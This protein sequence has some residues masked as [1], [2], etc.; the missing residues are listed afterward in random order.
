MPNRLKPNFKIEYESA[1]IVCLV[2][3]GPWDQYPTLTN[4]VE[5]VILELKHLGVLQLGTRLF[6]RDSEGQP[7]EILWSALRGNFEGFAPCL[8]V[9][10]DSFNALKVLEAYKG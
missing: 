3:L 7:G 10:V 4:A 2:D 1:N 9:D 8:G 5:V 6:Y